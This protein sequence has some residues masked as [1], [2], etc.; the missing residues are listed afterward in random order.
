MRAGIASQ[1]ELKIQTENRQERSGYQGHSIDNSTPNAQSPRLKDKCI[2]KTAAAFTANHAVQDQFLSSSP[3]GTTGVV[4]CNWDEKH[5]DW[6][7]VT[8]VSDFCE[9][10]A[11]SLA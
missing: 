9:A 5:Y 1:L 7:A 11:A 3:T 6:G 10:V 2:P 4:C 8:V